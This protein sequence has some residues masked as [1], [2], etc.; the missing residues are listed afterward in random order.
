MQNGPG[1]VEHRP[2]PRLRGPLERRGELRGDGRFAQ[3]GGEQRIREDRTAH[4]VE[5]RADRADD[6]RVPVPLELRFDRRKAED[7]VDR[8]QACEGLG[9]RVTRDSMGLRHVF[10]PERLR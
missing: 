1:E 6:G 4:A 2:Q 7:P 3:V 10:G 5:Q 8:G 9:L